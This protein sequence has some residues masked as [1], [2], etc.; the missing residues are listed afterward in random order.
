MTL[1][2]RA[3]QA[4]AV[5]GCRLQKDDCCCPNAARGPLWSNTVPAAAA[6][7]AS[8]VSVDSDDCDLEEASTTSGL[9]CRR[10]TSLTGPSLRR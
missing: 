9:V 5:V 8:P 3:I 1:C 2:S 7:A 4:K 10:R 6:A